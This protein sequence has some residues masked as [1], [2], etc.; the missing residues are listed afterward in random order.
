MDGANCLLKAKWSDLGPL[1]PIIWRTGCGR[2]RMHG[3]PARAVGVVSF[4]HRR[5]SIYVYNTCISCIITKSSRYVIF[6][7]TLNSKLHIQYT[8]LQLRQVSWNQ[9]RVSY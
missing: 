2:K 3:L 5:I 4:K 8:T 7:E 1:I 9:D 6:L